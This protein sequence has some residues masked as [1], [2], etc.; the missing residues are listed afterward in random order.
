MTDLSPLV[1][2]VCKNGRWEN[3]VEFDT[4][5][6]PNKLEFVKLRMLEK[7]NSNIP[8]DP[9][10][11]DKTLPVMPVDFEKLKN[12]DPDSI[13]VLWIGHATVFVQMEGI[14]ILC[15]PIF[16]ERCSPTFKVAGLELMK[17]FGYK[18]YRPVPCKIKELPPVDVVLI[19]HDHYDHL[20]TESIME[21]KESFPNAKYYVPMGLKDWFKDCG[22]QEVNVEE[23]NWWEE[24]Q[25]HLPDKQS[26][27]VTFACTPAQ[28]WCT[29]TGIDQNKRLWCSWVVKG[30]THSFYFGGDT[31]YN[32]IAFQ[33]IGKKY[34]PFSLSVLPIGAYEPRWY[35]H[36]Q[37]VSPEQSVDIHKEI[38]SKFSLGVHWGTFKQMGCFENYL[39][40]PTL[41]AERLRELNLPEN[42][43]RTIKHGEIWSISKEDVNPS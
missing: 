18:R 39:E 26:R 1:K 20:D 17:H 35:M 4:W 13:Q 43:F 40:P 31:G 2:A 30:E 6:M 16:S 36:P 23:K 41:V 37:H 10:E 19:S 34:G 3:P 33:Q 15:D 8:T 14:N 42:S 29:R 9:K 27:S 38:N 25:H 24:I 28:H 11:L 12:P 7:D 22:C 21:I 5:K 32:K